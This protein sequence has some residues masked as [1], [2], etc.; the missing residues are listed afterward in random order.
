METTKSLKLA[1][2]SGLINFILIGHSLHIKWSCSAML[3]LNFVASAHS[4]AYRT[5][6][7]F[8]RQHNKSKHEGKRR[9]NKL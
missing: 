9:R 8:F 2:A 3:L 6:L 5:G 4:H 1:N 7:D